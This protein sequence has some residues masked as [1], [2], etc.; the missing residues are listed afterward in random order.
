[1]S[2]PVTLLNQVLSIPILI[3]EAREKCLKIALI[4]MADFIKEEVS[5]FLIEISEI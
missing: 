2:W 5:K 3:A 4:K 1:M